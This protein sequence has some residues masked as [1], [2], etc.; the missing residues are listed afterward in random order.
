MS[1]RG[2]G[3][4]KAVVI[5]GPFKQVSAGRL[6][7]CVLL[8]EE[9]TQ[10]DRVVEDREETTE[11]E[12]STLEESTIEEEQVLED[13]TEM[14]ETKRESDKTTT[15]TTTSFAGLLK[16]W[17]LAATRIPSYERQKEL[18]RDESDETSGW[19]QVSVGTRLYVWYL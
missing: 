12:E 3:G 10:N 7:V 8:D 14:K 16:C 4:K 6:G 11:E 5:P 9:E 17:G 19:V 13:E 18:L 2:A 15:A 1:E